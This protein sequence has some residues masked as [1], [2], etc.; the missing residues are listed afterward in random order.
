MRRAEVQDLYLKQLV[1]TEQ[2]KTQDYFITGRYYYMAAARAYQANDTAMTN[3]AATKSRQ[4]FLPSSWKKHPKTIADICGEH[5][6]PHCS[7]P[8]EKPV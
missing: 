5:R 2:D 7:T 1:A 6:L 3:I 8:K 4:L